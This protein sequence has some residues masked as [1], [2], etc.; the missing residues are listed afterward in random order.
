MQFSSVRGSLSPMDAFTS[1]GG[2]ARGFGA[3]PWSAIQRLQEESGDSGRNEALESLLRRY[4]KPIYCFIRYETSESNEDAKDL[5]QQFLAWVLEGGRL[6]QVC[7]ERGRFRAFLKVALRR[8]LSN[9]FRARRALKRGGDRTFLD[10][11]AEIGLD[12]SSSKAPDPSAALDLEWKRVLL[13]DALELLRAS[14]A[15]EDLEIRYRVFEAYYFAPDPE[16]THRTVA[17]E[18]GVSAVDVNN[19]L[20]DVRRRFRRIVNDLIAESV[21]DEDEQRRE[22]EELFGQDVLP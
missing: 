17:A 15:A 22:L 16:R 14:L 13:G 3:T 8:F 10:I 21:L 7:Q 4:W 2:S 11:D 9:E 18:C 12:L 1:M 19:W 5:T 20:A 6:D